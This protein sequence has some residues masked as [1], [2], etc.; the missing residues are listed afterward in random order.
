MIETRKLIITR[1]VD[2]L[3]ATENIGRCSAPPCLGREAL[4]WN[5]PVVDVCDHRRSLVCLKDAGEQPQVQSNAQLN[6]SSTSAWESQF[7]V[8][9]IQSKIDSFI[10]CCEWLFQSSL[11]AHPGE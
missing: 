5:P 1:H 7:I 4:L 10:H 2:M 3:H 6:P 8:Y 11:P 9:R